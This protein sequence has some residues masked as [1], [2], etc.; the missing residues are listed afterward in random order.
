M[1]KIKIFLFLF[2]ALFLWACNNTN[3]LNKETPS[4]PSIKYEQC[5][6]VN[7]N[8]AN[9]EIKD[10]EI[11]WNDEDKK[12]NKVPDCKWTCIS[13][14]HEDNNQ[15]VKNNETEVKIIKIADE[16]YYYKGLSAPPTDWLNAGFNPENWETGISGFGYGDGD[17]NTKLTDMRDNYS[18]LY[19]R[20][21]FINNFTSVKTAVLK[22][23]YDDGFVAYINGTEVTR[24]NVNGIPLFNSL[25]SHSH[26]AS[27]GEGEIESFNIE[28]NNKLNKNDNS[29]QIIALNSTIDSSDLSIIPVL[30]ITGYL[31]DGISRAPLTP[32]D[33]TLT[34]ESANKVF[35]QWKDNSV[36]EDGFKIERATE[37]NGIISNFTEIATVAQNINTYYD[38]NLTLNKKYYYRI[39][40]FNS[41]GNSGNSNTE[42]VVIKDSWSFAVVADPRAAQDTFINALNEIKNLNINPNP[43]FSYPKFILMTGDS[44][45]NT[46]RYNDYKNIFTDLL[47]QGY[48]PVMGNHDYEEEDSHG[49]ILIN[50][51]SEQNNITRRNETDANYYF[52]I[53]NSRF[54][55]VDAYSSDTG[56]GGCINEKGKNWVEETINSATDKEHIFIAFHDPAFPR[57]RH[58]ES[59]FNECPNQRNDFWNMLIR[60]RDKVKAVF[61]GHTH[62]YYRMKVKTPD[63]SEANPS[64]EDAEAGLSLPDEEGGIYQIDAGAVGNGSVQNRSTIVRVKITGK[65]ILFRVLQAKRGSNEE[66]SVIDEW[67]IQ[68]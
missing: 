8:N 26:E 3:S 41:N 61:V 15:C 63:S 42:S 10:V 62:N 1:Q 17:D 21:N 43:K 30:T 18:T 67:K 56:S 13:S 9:T 59:S 65:E 40:A 51:L 14:F 36:N 11:K 38:N 29:L 32:T 19:I 48:Y 64:V 4:V 39:K 27:K 45:P 47:L 31:K 23:D 54:I 20:K 46:D 50:I 33:L 34:N 68:E 55:I 2:M 37:N 22:V 66:F 24:K 35:L 52:D 58:V 16:W 5:N 44:D 60:H 12:W 28:L 6:P 25:A 57:Y 49:A 7:V 53:K